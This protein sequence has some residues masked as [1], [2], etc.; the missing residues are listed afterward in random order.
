MAES[1]QH[2]AHTVAI[3]LVPTRFVWT[4]TPTASMFVVLAL[5]NPL[6]GIRHID[7]EPRDCFFGEPVES[8][9][10]K[11]VLRSNGLGTTTTHNADGKSI[12]AKHNSECVSYTS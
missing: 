3:H 7:I 4:P 12:R 8:V 5:H 9:S 1:R 6:T 11:Y 2:I 10:K